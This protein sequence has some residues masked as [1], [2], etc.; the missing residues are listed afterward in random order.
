[1]LPELRYFLLA[2][3]IIGFISLTG[4][5]AQS[6]DLD[7]RL[8]KKKNADE[9][10]YYD[11]NANTI[12]LYLTGR[13]GGQEFWDFDEENLKVYETIGSKKYTVPILFQGRISDTSSFTK[14]FVYL[15]KTSSEKKLHNQARTYE[16]VWKHLGRDTTV[17]LLKTWDTL[18]PIDLTEGLAFED[19]FASGAFLLVLLLVGL[20]EG[21]PFWRKQQFMRKHVRPYHQVQ[22]AGERKF[23]P[24][25]GRPI[26]ANDK[27]VVKCEQQTCGI[28]LDVWENR[29]FQCWHYP[30]QCKGAANIGFGQF[31]TQAGN[32]R[33]LNWLWFGVLGGLLAWALYFLFRQIAGRAA[34]AGEALSPILLGAALG[35]G[36]TSMLALVE[37]RGQGRELSLVRILIRTIA[38]AF[39]G[40]VLF[41]FSTLL[42]AHPAVSGLIWL[43]FCIVLGVVLSINSSISYRRGLISGLLAGGISGI[44]YVILLAAIPN[45]E[46]EFTS[47]LTFMVAGGVL[48]YVMMQVVSRLE[49]IELE[50]ISPNFRRGSVFPLDRLLNSGKPVIIGRDMKGCEV[51]VKWEDN[52][53]LPQHAVLDMKNNRVYIRPLG[54]AEIWIKDHPLQNGKTTLLEGGEIIRLGRH[55]QTAF[56]YLQK[57]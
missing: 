54:D 25:T 56:K 5:A 30:N 9:I 45:P 23:H 46:A 51:R 42:P 33:K 13:V 8:E 52:Y 49:R 29:N 36:I 35:L 48:G 6:T 43:L 19:V 4:V 34:I 1:M 28:P 14:E 57:T 38:G 10:I 20:S 31:F 55:S 47:L 41:Y 44:I 22:Q 21:I 12:D 37:E 2:F 40:A 3:F 32:F 39:A 26:G 24:I 27:V 50:V 53:V 11:G 7:L 17:Q 18:N 15:L 16:I